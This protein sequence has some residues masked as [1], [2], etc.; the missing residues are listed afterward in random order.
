MYTSNSFHNFLSPFM[1][2]SLLKFSLRVALTLTI[3]LHYGNSTA[4]TATLD[5]KLLLALA[6]LR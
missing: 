1:M 4:P 2:S 6:E 3:T 5:T